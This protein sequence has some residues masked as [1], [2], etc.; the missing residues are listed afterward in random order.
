MQT[1]LDAIAEV[2]KKKVSEETLFLVTFG[3]D[4]SFLLPH[5]AA[6]QLIDALAQAETYSGPYSK[7]VKIQEIK[8]D[9]FTIRQFSREK[10]YEIKA[11]NL[12]K[13]PYSEFVEQLG[14][15]E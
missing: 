13:V 14:T 7:P 9:D 15:V 10:Y 1:H 8:E 11:A 5:K 6:L 12:L 3:Y 4:N 2:K